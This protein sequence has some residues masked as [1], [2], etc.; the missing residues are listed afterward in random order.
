V[1]FVA[2][3]V[4]D[5][6]CELPAFV[7]IGAGLQNAGNG[8]IPGNSCDA[9]VVGG[10]GRPPENTRPTTDVPRFQRRLDLV[11]RMQVASGAGDVD[12]HRQIYADAS[13]MI[14]SPQMQ[15]FDLEREPTA[16]REAYGLN[17]QPV[18]G[19]RVG[20]QRPAVWRRVSACPPPGRGGRDVRRA[21]NAGWDTHNDNFTQSRTLC[22][23]FDQP[24]ACLLTDLQERGLL[25]KTLVVWMG[26]FGRTPRINP[27]AGRDHFPRASAPCLPVA[28]SAVACARRHRCGWRNHQRPPGHRERPVPDRLQDAG[29]RC[30]KEQ[31]SPIGRPSSSSMAARRCKNCLPDATRRAP[32]EELFMP[33]AFV[34]ALGGL[35]LLAT[36]ARAF[37][38]EAVIKQVD[39]GQRRLVVEADRAALDPGAGDVKVF[40]SAGKELAEG[41]KSPE[42]REGARVVLVVERVGDRPSLRQIRLGRG[43]EPPVASENTASAYQPVDTSGLIPLT[44]L[45]ERQYQGIVGGLYPQGK[46]RGRPVTKR[47]A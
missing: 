35:L 6:L 32:S 10:G 47:R 8:G 28:A 18:S 23:Q 5:A 39:P 25:D 3:E 9:F 1:R 4:R 11:G 24:F 46:V 36:A 33:R 14:L 42:L 7:R 27:R 37:E 22:G 43:P 34:L 12:D 21:G 20:Q 45:G 44:D 19:M 26:E 38:V 16:L 30:R 40:D 29:H 31:M 2:H 41:L 15:A 13:R 17:R